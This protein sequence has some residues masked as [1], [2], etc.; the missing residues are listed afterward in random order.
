MGCGQKKWA[1]AHFCGIK[2]GRKMS[3]I[4]SYKAT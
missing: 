2:V 3:E 4:T 1:K